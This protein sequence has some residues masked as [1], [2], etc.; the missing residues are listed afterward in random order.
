[1]SSQVEAPTPTPEATPSPTPEAV[2]PQADGSFG[3]SVDAFIQAFNVDWYEVAGVSNA[4]SDA[5]RGAGYLDGHPAYEFDIDAHS[6]IRLLHSPFVRISY[7]MNT[8]VQSDEVDDEHFDVMASIVVATGIAWDDAIEMIY[9]LMYETDGDGVIRSSY[10][11]VNGITY[12]LQ[13]NIM[14]IHSLTIEPVQ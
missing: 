6:F 9:R 14:G 2:Q 1:M 12:T 5:N 8:G 11:V 13:R 4:L 7:H 10:V 3:F